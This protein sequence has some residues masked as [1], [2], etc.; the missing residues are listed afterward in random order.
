MSLSPEQIEQRRHML[1]AS[2]AAAVLGLDPW[3]SPHEVYS[4]KVGEAPPRV[5]NWRM[6]RGNAIEPLLLEWLGEREAPLEVRRAGNVTLAHPI[7]DWLGAT[8][9]AL[10][11]EPGGKRPVGVGEAKSTGYKAAWLDENDNPIVPDYYAVQVIVQMAVVRVPITRVAVEVIG[12]AEPWI[13]PFERSEDDELAVL[14]GLERFWTDHVLAKVPPPLEEVGYR[15]VAAVYRRPK[16]DGFTVW[17]RDAEVAAQRY[18]KAKAVEA[19][20]KAVVEAAKTDLCKV[21]GDT[22]GVA[23]STWRATWK[24]RSATRIA[25]ERPEYRHFDLRAVGTERRRRKGSEAT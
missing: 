1:T 7:L 20:A 5:Q 15:E 12:E 17:T 16:T 8:P 18:L 25:Y 24:T 6:R 4:E 23:G 21:I 14:E 9:D 10:L 22:S 3:R 19:R 2:D 13:L 11:F